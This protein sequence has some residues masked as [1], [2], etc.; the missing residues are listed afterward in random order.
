MAEPIELPRCLRRVYEQLFPT[1]NFDRITFL[2][3]DPDPPYRTDAGFTKALS[4][5][6]FEIYIVSTYYPCSLDTFCLIAHELVH[7]M[8]YQTVGRTPLEMDY[9]QCLMMGRGTEEENAIE[10]VAYAYE[11][12]LRACIEDVWDAMRPCGCSFEADST[13]TNNNDLIEHIQHNCPELILRRVDVPSCDETLGEPKIRQWYKVVLYWIAKIAVEFVAYIF[14]AVRNAV[15]GKG[16]RP[17]RVMFS[18]T[19]GASFN[20][21]TN[22]PIGQSGEPPAVAFT[23]PTSGEESVYVAWA[24]RS[25]HITILRIPEGERSLHEGYSSDDS[26]PSLTCD[27]R[28]PWLL[29]QHR[30]NKLRLRRLELTGAVDNGF[31]P[32][33]VKAKVPDDVT[34]GLTTGNGDIFVGWARKNRDNKVSIKST[35][36]GGVTWRNHITL[37]QHTRNEGSVALC[38]GVDKLYLAW[39]GRKNQVI[40]LMTFDVSR[41][42]LITREPAFHKKLDVRCAKKSGPAIAYGNNRLFLAFT[43]RRKGNLHVMTFQ[44]DANGVPQANNPEHHLRLSQMSRMNAGPGLAFAD[45][46]AGNR[47]L[48]LSWIQKK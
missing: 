4:G 11:E 28:H 14:N 20:E 37:E 44:V 25:N 19:D 7:V 9:F 21:D 31:A 3:G 38:F 42:G 43:G 35:A 40:H 24:K 18:L 29:W 13:P 41:D 33:I 23:D 26:G 22:R 1:L 16:P 10:A 6:R 39:A 2:L 36:D 45:Y 30:S 15:F 48:C 5:N 46:G 17:V 47:V 34:P 27:A 32:V 12:N 8:Q